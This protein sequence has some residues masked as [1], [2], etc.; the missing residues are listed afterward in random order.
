MKILFITYENI[1]HACPRYRAFWPA[2]GLQI[3][4]H[5]TRV[6][7]LKE[8]GKKD[9]EWADAVVFERIVEAMAYEPDHY[10]RVRR[11]R[12]I[13][14]LWNY[15]LLR[16]ITAYDLDDYIFFSDDGFRFYKICS[17]LQKALMKYSNYVSTSSAFLASIISNYNNQVFQLDN[18]IDTMSIRDVPGIRGAGD[19][20]TL[21]W[22]CGQTHHRDEPVMLDIIKPLIDKYGQAIRF[23]FVGKISSRML[24][25]LDPYS[26]HIMIENY[27]NWRLLPTLQKHV[28]I[29]LVPLLPCAL[30]QGKSAISYLESGFLKIPSVCSRIGEF[31]TIIKD[32]D[33][34]FLAATAP[35]W[36][37]K[38]GMLIEDATLRR[39]MGE[40]AYQDVMSTYTINT[41]GDRYSRFL[42]MMPL[43]PITVRLRKSTAANTFFL[44]KWLQVL[45]LY[46]I[47]MVKDGFN[48]VLERVMHWV[49]DQIK[50][51]VLYMSHKRRL[52]CSP[53]TFTRSWHVT[54]VEEHIFLGLDA[55][56]STVSRLNND[57]RIVF[58][59]HDIS[60]NKRIEPFI[61][62]A[63]W[64]AEKGKRVV[65]V[66]PKAIR[67]RLKPYLNPHVILQEQRPKKT[68]REL[69]FTQEE[70][71]AI[72]KKR[73][74]V[75][76][77]PY[78]FSPLVINKIIS[79]RLGLYAGSTG[80]T[81]KVAG[82]IS[83][84][85]KD[86][87]RNMQLIILNSLASSIFCP[88]CK[89]S[90]VNYE[91]PECLAQ[92]YS[93]VDAFLMLDDGADS[94]QMVLEAMSCGTPVIS[95]PLDKNFFED[96]FNILYY[97]QT[98][99]PSLCDCI[100]TV[101]EKYSY[102]ERLISEGHNCAKQFDPSD[103][104]QYFDRII[105]EELANE[106]TIP[107]TI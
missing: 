18:C 86:R 56:N 3:A 8:C 85:F 20:I 84:Y 71:Y 82:E 13:M 87:Y 48:S 31:S 70:C 16:K 17:W 11:A 22:L 78:I 26:S 53:I 60:L 7:L 93:G 62:I 12:K 10:M 40:R 91:G 103:S 61:S 106:D 81:E 2:K 95:K 44:F 83:S 76:V 75:L 63:N 58:E 64:I 14:G 59:V 68:Q 50:K 67:G 94:I 6:L 90:T 35:E 77:D 29:N 92:F 46:L 99:S 32:G 41:Q 5:C 107:V 39:E 89:I 45:F 49:K 72:I 52:D 100:T 57:G 4:G 42:A 28:D 34:G 47:S 37:D 98:R 25:L 1:D 69:H 74:Q 27:R 105:N 65:I 30:N 54:D 36:V 97:N 38:L 102:R 33:N 101:L 15:A 21:G 88:Y 79:F 43:P 19:R 23:L 9:I 55:I 80:D 66:A 96:G 73:S 24:S 104:L 51:T